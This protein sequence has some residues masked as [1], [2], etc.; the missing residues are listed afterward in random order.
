[1]K[2]VKF[3]KLRLNY[4]ILNFWRTLAGI[5]NIFYNSERVCKQIP[6]GSYLSVNSKLFRNQQ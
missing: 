3:Q 2:S 5:C 1:M 6:Q 4:I